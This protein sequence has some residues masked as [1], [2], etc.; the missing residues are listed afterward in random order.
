MELK[1]SH[2]E[3]PCEE[4]LQVCMQLEKLFP[5]Y[6]WISFLILIYIFSFNIY[7][8]IS[9]LKLQDHLTSTRIICMHICILVYQYKSA[10]LKK[11]FLKYN[12]Y[13]FVWNIFKYIITSFEICN[14]IKPI[15]YIVIYSVHCIIR[16]YYVYLIRLGVLFVHTVQNAKQ[17]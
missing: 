17:V 6:D 5:I 15:I 4:D 3:I 12:Y 11:N 14:T 2:K 16:I 13:K 1:Q 10:F 7:F 9:N 8:F